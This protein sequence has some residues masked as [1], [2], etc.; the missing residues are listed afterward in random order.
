MFGI[1]FFQ[2]LKIN[3]LREA[4]QHSSSRQFRDTRNIS[5]IHALFLMHIHGIKL[6]E[7]YVT[8]YITTDDLL[9]GNMNT[10][11]NATKSDAFNKH[12]SVYRLNMGDQG[13]LMRYKQYYFLQF[14]QLFI[15]PE[16]IQQLLDEIEHDI[17]TI[18]FILATM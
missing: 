13:R 16:T 6:C 12:C 4:F 7:C 17:K 1:V 18:R 14:S 15:E 10:L 9:E 3:G 8:K 2:N 5:H 11:Y